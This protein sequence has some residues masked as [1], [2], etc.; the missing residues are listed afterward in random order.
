MKVGDRVK[1]RNWC[2]KG[3]FAPFFKAYKGHEFVVTGFMPNDEGPGFIK[4][5][6]GLKCVTGSVTVKGYVHDF[7]LEVV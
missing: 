1:F 6:V 3:G 7:D 2:F 4:D 5:H